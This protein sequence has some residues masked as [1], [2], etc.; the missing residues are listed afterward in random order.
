M[1]IKDLETFAL[2]MDSGSLS[3]ASEQLGLTQ[4]AMSLK[5]KKIEMDL[6]IPLFLRTPKKLEPLETAK[7]IAP[8]VRS[9]LSNIDG[10]KEAVIA[11]INELQGFVKVGCLTGWFEPLLVKSV[12]NINKIAP[13][14]KMRLHV[15][16][17][18]N[19]L[20]MINYGKLDLAIIAQPFERMDG[21]ESELLLE[22]ELVLS[23]Q[24]LPKTT[25]LVELEEALIARPWV[26]MT[27][28]D[29]L[30][31]KWWRDLFNKEFPW[32]KAIVP[33]TVDHI[34][35]VI[36]VMK[37]I[38]NAIAILPKQVVLE[39]HDYMPLHEGQ[40]KR[41]N[42]YLV[43]RSEGIELRRYQLVIEKIKEQAQEWAMKN[44]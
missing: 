38:P 10:L 1:D 28:P 35:S 26:A 19:L 5:L 14:V 42:L 12:V 4:P 7:T 36:S 3:K 31:E 17:T 6:G 22:E 16:S 41:N 43:W 18:E 24:N 15:D 44:K 40:T 20:S 21:I 8:L 23:G 39:H 27:V 37:S 32:D 34:T 25:D 33:V 29:L 2:I 13:R 9:I 11:N 30:V